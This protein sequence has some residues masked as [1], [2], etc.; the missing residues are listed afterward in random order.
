MRR[1]HLVPDHA[2]EQAA[3]DAVVRTADG[4]P[5]RRTETM[6]GVVR[7][8]TSAPSIRLRRV[9]RLRGAS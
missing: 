6:D 3:G 9:E 7:T 5:E 1:L 2:D 8:I 4:A